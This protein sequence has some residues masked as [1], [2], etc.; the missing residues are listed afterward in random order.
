ME[1]GDKKWSVWMCGQLGSGLTIPFDVSGPVH[2]YHQLSAN[3]GKPLKPF[4]LS[5]SVVAYYIQRLYRNSGASALSRLEAQNIAG[6]HGTAAKRKVSTL[7]R[8]IGPGQRFRMSLLG[9]GDPYA[10][11]RGQHSEAVNLPIYDTERRAEQSPSRESEQI[12]H[13][14]TCQDRSRGRGFQ[15][16][17][18][19]RPGSPFAI[20]NEETSI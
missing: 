5:P 10:S 8:T 1:E 19:P 11:E 15:G 18:P 14:I 2:V 13:E 7:R 3:H 12:T 9:T 4:L 17:E 20:S 16:R 6:V